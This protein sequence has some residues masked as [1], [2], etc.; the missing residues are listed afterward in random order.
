MRRF[1]LIIP[2]LA[3]GGFLRA[4][5][6]FEQGNT[7][8]Q[9]GNYDAARE[10]YENLVAA[11]N[12][13]LALSYNLGNTY[14]RLG[15]MGLARLWYERALE[16]APRDED[17]RHNRNLVRERV[18]E[19]ETE[20]FGLQDL[21]GILWGVATGINVIFF[22][23]LCLGLFRDWEWVWWGRWVAGILLAILLMAAVS[24]QRQTSIPYGVILTARAEARTG[25]SDQEKVGFIAP[26]GHRVVL[27]GSL[28]DWVQIG[29]PAKGLK[30]WVPKNTVEPVNP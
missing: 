1:L 15:Q 11:G 3:L 9:E 27:L 2:L 8:Y 25:P 14:F 7:A 30:G 13:G 24:A 21:T 5:G 19:T 22:T 29:V 20:S 4:E 6:T 23:L 18:G 28:N 17:T 12:G 10:V 16:A 26:E